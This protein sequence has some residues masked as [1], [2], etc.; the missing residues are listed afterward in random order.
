M[1]LRFGRRVAPEL[2]EELAREPNWM[3]LWPL[4]KGHQLK[5]LGAELD[6]V[7]TTRAEMIEPAVRAALAQSPSATAI[8]LACSEG[9]FA[10]R[11]LDWGAKRVIGLD[12]REQNI[13]RARLMREHFAIPPERLE[14]RRADLFDLPLIAKEQYDVVL[15]LGLV[16]HVEDP[17]GA[18]RRSRAL[19][20]SLMVVESQL[21]RQAAPIVHGWG[22]SDSAEEA[23]GSF[24]TRMELDAELN[25]VASSGGVLSLI[26]N[27]VALEQMAIVAGFSRTE[28][29]A[30]S[31]HH[32]QQ[33]VLGD[34]A[35]MLAWV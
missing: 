35:V 8:D 4:P 30:A 20:R 6:S 5:P 23:R 10:H 13:H 3:Y 18:F 28:I 22:T 34:R 25:P 19:T 7:H 24:A 12:I 2:R 14:L 9:W 11:L 21:T 33:Y 31:P 1:R 16:Y 27:R 17:V 32:N 15:L 26:P 29:I